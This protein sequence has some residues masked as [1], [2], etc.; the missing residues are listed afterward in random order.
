MPASMPPLPEGCLH[1]RSAGFDGVLGAARIALIRDATL[2]TLAEYHRREPDE[3]GPDTGRLRR[4]SAPRLPAPLWSALLARLADDGLVKLHGPYVHLPE[5][6]VQLSVSEER[7]VQKTAPLF[8]RAGFEGAWARDLARDAREP[9]PLMRTTLARMA[10]RGDLHQ[11]VKDLYY[12][13]ETM[14]RLAAI[15]RTLADEDGG[16]ITAARF[17]D[18]TGLGRKRAIQIL[19]HFDRVGLLRRVGDVHKLRTDTALF[20]PEDART[21]ARRVDEPVADESAAEDRR[22]G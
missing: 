9:E 16:G 14:S 18:A 12:A 2:A 13:G 8:E 10:R 20:T 19:E 21:G 3:F 15:V 17:R 1:A 6:G 22:G 5:H 11:V 4:S 7:I